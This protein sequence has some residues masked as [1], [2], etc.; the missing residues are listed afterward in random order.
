MCMSTFPAKPFFGG[1]ERGVTEAKRM[2]LRLR[3]GRGHVQLSGQ[4]FPVRKNNGENSAAR[5]GVR[6]PRGTA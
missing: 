1:R 3:L 4:P 5:K 2:L 6:G